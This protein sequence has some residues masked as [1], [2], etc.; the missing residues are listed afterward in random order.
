[1]SRN[2]RNQSAHDDLVLDLALTLENQ[3]WNVQADVPNFD[4][5]D[6]IGNEGKIPDIFATQGDQIKIIEVETPRTLNSHQ[7]QH[8][9]FKRSA[10]QRENAEFEL[11]VAEPNKS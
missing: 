7:V 4:Q 9:T 6:P 10:A 2:Q 3:G 11:V 1:M 8:S 5:P